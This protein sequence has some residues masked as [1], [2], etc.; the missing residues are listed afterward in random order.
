MLDRML[1]ILLAELNLLPAMDDYFDVL[2]K[3]SI[4]PA[5]GASVFPIFPDKDLTCA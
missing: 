3:R 5:K 4:L 1:Q 2:N